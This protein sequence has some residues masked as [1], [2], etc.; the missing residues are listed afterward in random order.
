MLLGREESLEEEFVVGLEVFLRFAV[1][2]L[3]RRQRV[4]R[5]GERL[6][7]HQVGLDPRQHLSAFHDVAVAMEDLHDLTGDGRFH[8]DLHFRFDG[9]D[10]GDFDL[11]IGDLRLAG[12]HRRFRQLLVLAIGLDCN[13]A[14]DD[15]EQQNDR[16][17]RDPAFPLR[18][19][20]TSS[21]S[22]LEAVF[23]PRAK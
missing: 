8:F 5:V 16:D 10:L 4:L 21:E 3:R 7:L 23:V 19:H 18:A 2:D 14:A 1:A 22:C 6:R 12:L 17:N 11:H 20:F 13:R 15:D 9:A